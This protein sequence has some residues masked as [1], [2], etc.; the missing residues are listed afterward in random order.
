MWYIKKMEVDLFNFSPEKNKQLIE[1]RGISFEEVIETILE[2]DVVDITDHP[3]QK[4]YPKQ[5][6]YILNINDY[7]YSVPFVLEKDNTV[8]LKTIIPS[9]KLTKQYLSKEK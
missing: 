2:G 1:Q 3:N 4:K 5:K 8:F 7:L 6:V 9:R